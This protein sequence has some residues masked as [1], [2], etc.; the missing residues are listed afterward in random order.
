MNLPIQ[1]LAVADT[2][3]P[4]EHFAKNGYYQV[5]NQ[6]FNH[7]IMALQYATA[8]KQSVN[9]NFNNKVYDS[10]DWIKQDSIGLLSMY[11][12]RAEQLRNKYD[13]LILCWS[14]GAD[15]TAMLES[16]LH[17]NILLDEVVILW[18]VSRTRG[19]Y[20]PNWN[21]HSFNMPSEWELAVVPQLEKIKKDY[22]KLKI[23]ICDTMDKLETN[24]YRDDTVLV[25]EKHNYGSI[26]RWRQLDE[27]ARK[28]SEKYHNVAILL[29]VSP[30]HVANLDDKYL[31]TF[32]TDSFVS[33]G[34]K[35][36]RT[37]DGWLR[38]VEFF[39]MT[40]DMPELMRKQAHVMLEHMKMNPQAKKYVSAMTMTKHRT[41]KMVYNPDSEIFRQYRKSL[42]YPNYDINTFQVRKQEDT[43]DR[44]DWFEWFFQ[45][46]HSEPFL[47]PWRSAVKAHQ[48]LIDPKFFQIVNGRVADYMEFCT[49]FYIVGKL[50]DI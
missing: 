39:Y 33:P 31:V 12:M 17:N 28:R 32:F 13:Y 38:N 40:P 20:T 4:L 2:T 34:S 35:S 29:G 3:A 11:K 44:A 47:L 27:V 26:Q 41:L 7:K 45:D 19:R 25:C 18:P 5:G 14:G 50:N 36:D 21:T 23:T 22:P 30:V 8:T 42:L 6:V 1:K 49:K 15:S 9:W 24:E 48:N 10:L 16:F 46:P 43:H 37:Q